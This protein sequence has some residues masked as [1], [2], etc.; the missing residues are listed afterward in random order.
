MATEPQTPVAIASIPGARPA[1]LGGRP[2]FP[3]GL[4]LARPGVRDPDRVAR[5]VRRILESGR[6]TDGPFV[7]ELERQVAE[8]LGVRHCVAVSSCTAGLMLVLRAADLAG[9]VVLPSFTFA[10][11][12]HAVAWNG[13]RPVFADVD[14]ASLTLS[15]ESVR[16]V[17]G[18]RTVAIVATHVY[19][20]PC[21]EEALSA[22]AREDGIRLFFDAAHAL[23]SLHRGVPV[24][25]FGDA[26]VFSLSPTKVVIA[27]EGGLIT[28]DDDLLAERCRIGRDYGNP[29]DYDCRFVGLNARMSEVHAAIALA[30]MEDLEER[31]AR[32]N[33]LA[34]GYVEVLTGIPGLRFPTVADGDRS[35]FKDFTILVDPEGFGLTADDLSG[36]LAPEGIE[37]KRYYAPP[38]HRMRAY[39]AVAETNGGLPVTDRAST[40]AL[41]LPMWADMTEAH[42]RGVAEAIDRVRR[43]LGRGFGAWGSAE[44]LRRTRDDPLPSPGLPSTLNSI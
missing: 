33:S 30:S 1:V 40:Q 23:G 26:E 4:P 12:A 3:E 8:Y 32:R 42:L 39:R 37:T 31:I 20:T 15:A 27:A 16:R 17:V 10:A 24:G 36:A 9:D 38:V 7:R 22:L 44:K 21:D 6:L 2:I 19:G 29:G 34:A 13:L 14:P 35:T 5:D 41:T 11:T 25:G 18:V 28:T 43:H